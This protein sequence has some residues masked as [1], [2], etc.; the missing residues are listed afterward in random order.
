ML[1][2]II[3]VDK[4]GN[5]PYLLFDIAQNQILTYSK[6]QWSRSNDNTLK[7]QNLVSVMIFL[8]DINTWYVKMR[9]NKPVRHLYADICMTAHY[10]PRRSGD[11]P[12]LK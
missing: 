11:M 1:N 5:I 6:G 2:I 9:Q 8:F 10:I 3:F 12:P 4:I 7:S